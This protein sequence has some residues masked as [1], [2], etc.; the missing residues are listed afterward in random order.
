MQSHYSQLPSS[1]LAVLEQLIYIRL[2]IDIW[3]S[4]YQI[5]DLLS[6]LILENVAIV[7]ALQLEV[8][9]HHASLFPL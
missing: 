4:G 2:L 8:A 6:F 9:R 3:I 7:N 5:L 1:I